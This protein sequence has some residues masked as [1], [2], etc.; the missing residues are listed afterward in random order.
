MLPLGRM[1]YLVSIQNP[2]TA[3]DAL[4]APVQTWA[5]YQTVYAAIENDAYSAE[6]D[7]GAPHESNIQTRVYILRNHRDFNFNTQQR[8]LDRGSV[9]A[10]T[11]IRYDA[12]ATVCYLDCVSG[13]SSG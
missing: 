6:E 5:D 8:L 2:V 7:N 13:A 9:F 10:I 4:G 12:K 1:N 3:K 11:A